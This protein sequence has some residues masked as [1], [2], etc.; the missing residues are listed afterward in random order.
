MVSIANY[1]P[2]NEVLHSHPAASVPKQI[3]KA[4]PLDAAN[5]S[6]GHAWLPVPSASAKLKS[7]IGTTP[8]GMPQ[9]PPSNSAL[10]SVAAHTTPG[11]QFLRFPPTSQ[12]LSEE[13][14]DPYFINFE[15]GSKE[16]ENLLQGSMEKSNRRMLTHYASLAEDMAEL[17][18]RYNAFS[19]SEQ[20]S[21]LATA[22]EKM[23]QAVDSTYVKT[24]DLSS[25]L[26]AH[27]AEPMRESAQFAGVV[28]NVL[29]YRV[30]KRVQEQMT[31]DEL[32]K[33]K[34]LLANLNEQEE[35]SKRMAA[36][37]SGYTTQ[38]P[39]TPK[40]SMSSASGRMSQDSQRRGE[41]DVASVDSDFPPTIGDAS[42]PS[43]PQGLPQGAEP[44]S[45]TPNH[46]KSGSSGGNFMSN[47][48]FG[49][50]SHA[51]HGVVDSDPVKTRHDLI[52]KTSEQV[53]QLTEGLKVVKTDVKDAS[54]GVLED[55]KRF[56]GEKEEDLKRYMV[57]LSNFTFWIH[58]DN[59]VQVAF[60]HCHIAWAKDNLSSWE[61]AKNEVENIQVQDPRE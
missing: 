2:Q 22:I 28:R 5:P 47:K 20:S 41:E 58:A 9:S 48:I 19:L 61:E 42:P 31:E 45:P 39:T 8:S 26:S 57:R 36:T 24:R 3:L 53:E 43:A 14:L 4:P 29:R 1:L 35:Q 6:P 13:D 32:K 16:L 49:R 52:G 60:A 59:E 30:L 12:N 54:K 23:G 25:E 10:P 40:R 21:T 44:S 46:K 34:E 15:A 18:A 11:P 27:F 17:G 33:K 38:S 50:I 56:Q 7:N 55:L 51:F 37:L